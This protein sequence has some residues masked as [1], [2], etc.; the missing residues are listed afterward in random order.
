[1]TKRAR[2]WLL[3][4][5]P[6]LWLGC[7]YPADDDYAES[8]DYLVEDAWLSGDLPDVGRFDADAY[9]VELGW[10]EVTLHAGRDGGDDFG[11]A[12]TRLALSVD[13]L[14]EMEGTQ[15]GGWATG[16][17]GPR[18]GSWDWDDSTSDVQVTVSPGPAAG[19]RLV[20]FVADFGGGQRSEGGFILRPR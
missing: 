1:M 16:C 19:E 8:S 12:M 6:I 4:L 15:D 17:S 18:H 10:D 3:A 13:E 2:L 9:E 14:A 7:L 20:H 11:W 5:G